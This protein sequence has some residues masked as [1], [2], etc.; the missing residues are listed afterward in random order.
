[1][2]IVFVERTA[3]ILAV[4][5]IIRERIG[6][7]SELLYP[8]D[9]GYNRTII[10]YGVSSVIPSICSVEPGDINDVSTVVSPFDLSNGMIRSIYL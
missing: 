6:S 4:C 2:R 9:L 8:S 7:S 5:Q 10:R 3:A 1:M